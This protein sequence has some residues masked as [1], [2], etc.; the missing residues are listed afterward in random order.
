[1]SLA[2]RTKMDNSILIR[3]GTPKH[4]WLPVVFHHKNFQLHFEASDGLNDPIGELFSA[5]TQNGLLR[6]TWWLEPAA[7]FFDIDKDGDNVTVN[8]METEDIHDE[9]VTEKLLAEIVGSKME[10]IDPI[11]NSLRQYSSKD[12]DENHWPYKLE[13]EK[14]KNL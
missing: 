9:T 3:F 4:G 7:Y 13:K 8:I 1:M 10:I 12:Y 2:N 14:L 11:L 5:V 6:V